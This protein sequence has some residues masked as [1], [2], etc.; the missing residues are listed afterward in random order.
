MLGVVVVPLALVVT[1]NSYSAPGPDAYVR[2]AFAQV[3]G[4]TIAIVT[5]LALLLHRILS[6]S[7]VGTIA[8]FAFI[9]IVVISFQAFRL[10]DAASFLLTGLGIET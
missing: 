10:A 5:V 7:P 8:W 3:A 1:F 2:M 6:R 4:S 9:A